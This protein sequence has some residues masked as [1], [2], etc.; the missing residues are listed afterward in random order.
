M[1]AITWPCNQKAVYWAP[2]SEESGGVDFDDYG[3]PQYSSPVEIDCRW[4]DIDEEIISPT[5]DVTMSKAVVIVDREVKKRGVLWLGELSSVEDEDN[6]ENNE[7]AW[8]IIK[9]AQTP[10]VDGE[11]KLIRAFL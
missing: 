10:D 1:E 8:E 5:G 3:T 7:N 9:V 4:D 6:P 11:E 2:G